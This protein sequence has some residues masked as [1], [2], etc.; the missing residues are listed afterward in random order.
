MAAYSSFQFSVVDDIR[1]V[2]KTKLD[3][4]FCICWTHYA[5]YVLFPSGTN[6]NSEIQDHSTFK[7]VFYL[8]YER[9]YKQ[10]SGR[11][12]NGKSYVTPL[13]FFRL[14]YQ[15]HRKILLTIVVI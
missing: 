1:E 9:L 8:R 11:K 6:R 13:G 14:E 4:L 3:S 5:G 15:C 7:F 12:V 10:L 2:C